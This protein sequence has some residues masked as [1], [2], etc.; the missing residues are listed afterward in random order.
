VR[1]TNASDRAWLA[2]EL[3]ERGMR[4]F[5]SQTNFLLVDTGGEA[6]ALEARLF[7]A[8]VIVRPMAGYG[9]GQTVRISI[10]SRA[11]LDRLLEQLK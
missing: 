5:P 11:E 6:T 3:V 9:L 2:G 8:G 7:A 10:G 4:V 1:D